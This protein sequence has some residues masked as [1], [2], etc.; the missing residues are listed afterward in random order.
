MR[1]LMGNVSGLR[2]SLDISWLFSGITQAVSVADVLSFYRDVDDVN[3]A[4][5]TSWCYSNGSFLL[6]TVAIERI[7]GQALEDVLRERIFER[8]G[9]HDTLLRRLGTDFVA[10]SATMHMVDPTGAY[11]RSYVGSALTGEGGMA[12]TVDDM[13]RW[14]GHMDAPRVGSATTWGIM[15]TPQALNNGTSVGYGLGLVVCRYR[16]VERLSHSGGGLGASSQMLKVPS[17]GLDIIIMVNRHDVSAMLLADKILDA[18]LPDLEPPKTVTTRS[19]PTGIFCSPTTGRVIQLGIY[20]NR[21]VWIKEGQPFALI[22]GSE[23]PIESDDDGVFRPTGYS[24]YLQRSVTIL[25]GPGHP[26]S[27]RFS[28]VGNLDDLVLVPP[29]KAH[30]IAPIAGRYR[31]ESTGTQLTILEGE[32]GPRLISA[33]RFGST[34]FTLE[35]L[36]HG[37]W[38]AKSP[39]LGWGGILV[40][41][42]DNAGLRF[43]SSRIR[44]LSF[45]R[46]I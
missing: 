44:M 13:L 18:C 3:F 45:R 30:D 35:C 6:L 2:D 5:G 25:G 31:S 41:D 39:P 9:M 20:A 29:V 23:F 14:L 12:S 40:F 22:D 36:A 34:E 28:D 8:V 38:R 32:N 11:N 17:A 10:N 43:S 21:S 4:P 27:I 7:T 42:R 15:T 16:G 33:G 19:F 37:I 46:C 1:Q 24:N 26:T